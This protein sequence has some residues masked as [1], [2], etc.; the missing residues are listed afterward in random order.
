MR[1]YSR[2]VANPGK[3]IYEI[4]KSGRVVVV[5]EDLLKLIADDHHRNVGAQKPL[6]G[7]KE[8]RDLAACVAAKEGAQ[9][10]TAAFG[11][12]QRRDS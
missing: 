11:A 7:L 3:C 12:C 8:F 5:N 10:R 4:F 6:R 9:I 2:I 1:P